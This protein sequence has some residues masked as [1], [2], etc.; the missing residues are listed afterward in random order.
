[1]RQFITLSNLCG[2]LLTGCALTGCATVPPPAVAA[3]STH[4][5]VRTATSAPPA[6]PVYLAEGEVLTGTTVLRPG[7]V[8]GCPLNGLGTVVLYHMT[9]QR[10]TGQTATGTGWE[11]IQSCAVYC[12]G[13]PQ[14]RV[15]AVAISLSRPVRDCAIGL[16]VWTRATFRYPDGLGRAPAPPDPLDLTTLAAAARASCHPA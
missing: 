11:T 5:H 12:S 14:Y 1:V 8:A 15:P 7:C 13:Q 9:W 6:P 10:W 4:A 16:S 2:L 3:R